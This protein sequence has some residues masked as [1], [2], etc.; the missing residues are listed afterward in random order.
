MIQL[1]NLAALICIVLGVMALLKP[2]VLARLLSLRPN[3]LAGSAE[4]RATYGGMLIGM[5]ALGLISQH[6]M[7]FITLAIGWLSAAS[8]RLFAIIYRPSN[9]AML[10]GV[11]VE[12]TIGLLFISAW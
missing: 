6:P 5:A 10:A 4:I 3:G 2:D 8:V 7:V 1:Y 9:M 11:A 12:G